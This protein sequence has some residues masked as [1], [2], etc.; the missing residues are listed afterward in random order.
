MENLTKNGITSMEQILSISAQCML[1]LFQ[2]KG[3]LNLNEGKER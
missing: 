2:K 3:E 1:K